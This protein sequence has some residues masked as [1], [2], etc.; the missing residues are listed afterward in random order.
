MCMASNSDKFFRGISVQTL[1]TITFGILEILVF[2]I[3][4]RL[5]SKTDFGYFAAITGVMAILMSVSEAGLGSAVIQKKDASKSFISTA[6]TLSCIVGFVISALLFGF[7][8]YLADL[9][10]DSTLTMPLR[11][12]SIN[13][14]L[15]GIISIGNGVLYRRLAF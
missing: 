12:M 14:F 6:F 15:Y 9:I 11:V 2:S 7:A 5:L 8:P 1:V 4:S 10:A 13:I 3:M